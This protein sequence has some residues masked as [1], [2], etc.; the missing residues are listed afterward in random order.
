MDTVYLDTNVYVACYGDRRGKKALIS[1]SEESDKL[2]QKIREGKCKLTTS[3]HL[4]RQLDV[5]LPKYM[6]FVK[7]L[8][9]L[10]LRN[11]VTVESTDIEAAEKEVSLLPKNATD[12][13]DALHFV[14]AKKAG[15][16]YLVTWNLPDFNWFQKRI[17]VVTPNG[18]GSPW[19]PRCNMCQ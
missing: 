10:G 3:D 6:Q 11:Q 8:D 13:E 16:H 1:E 5:Y 19:V 7:E 14:L 17:H 12:F 9:G 2:L 18:V 4:E 15:V